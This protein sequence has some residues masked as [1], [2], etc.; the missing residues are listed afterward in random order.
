MYKIILSALLFLVFNSVNAQDWLTNFDNAKVE[1]N[2]K[3]QHIILV[4]QGSDWCAPC[5]KLNQ[6]IWS[7]PEFITYSK[8]HFVMLKADFPRKNKNKL[9]DAQQEK[10][11]QLM[12]KYNKQGYFPFVAVLDKDGNVLGNTGYKKTSPAEYINLLNS[13]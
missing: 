8:E 12:E 11:N 7:S 1:A 4:F 6:E 3:N 5:I 13:F 2:K 10:N 9:V